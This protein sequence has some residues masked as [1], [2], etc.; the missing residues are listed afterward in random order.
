M[1]K[2]VTLRELG[3]GAE[4]QPRVFREGFHDEIWKRSRQEHPG[5]EVAHSKAMRARKEGGED[6]HLAK[7]E[8]RQAGAALPSGAWVAVLG[9]LSFSNWTGVPCCQARG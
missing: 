1:G 4:C 2:D 6:S 3:Y 7:A 5:K 9:V 8:K